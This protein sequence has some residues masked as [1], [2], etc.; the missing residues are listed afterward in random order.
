[1]KNWSRETQSFIGMTIEDFQNYL[2]ANF[3][4]KT[5]DGKEWLMDKVIADRIWEAC[6]AT[7]S[8]LPLA[9]W[10]TEIDRKRKAAR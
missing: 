2:M 10:Q 7:K 3:T 5:A 6:T 1:V 9:S 8:P 4:L